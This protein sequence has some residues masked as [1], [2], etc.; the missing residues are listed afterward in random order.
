M[1]GIQDLREQA[2]QQNSLNFWSGLFAVA[3][4]APDNGKQV[5][6]RL[7][8]QQLTSVLCSA[9]ASGDGGE[10]ASSGASSNQ[11]FSGGPGPGLKGITLPLHTRAKIWGEN[12]LQTI[13]QQKWNVA[14]VEQI[15]L[16]IMRSSGLTEVFAALLKRLEATAVCGD[17]VE[18]AAVLPG[19]RH[20]QECQNN[21][22]KCREMLFIAKWLTATSNTKYDA[23]KL[24]DTFNIRRQRIN[25][26][27]FEED[28]D[29]DTGARLAIDCLVGQ[30]NINI[31]PTAHAQAT[32]NA[33]ANA[34]D[35]DPNRA[36]GSFP[37]W[38]PPINPCRELTGT[39]ARLCVALYLCLE[40]NAPSTAVQAQAQAT[41][42]SSS[43]VNVNGTN[44]NAM[45]AGQQFAASVQ[46]PKQISNVVCAL[47]TLDR[48]NDDDV[49]NSDAEMRAIRTF[50][51]C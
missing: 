44:E 3:T 48:L 39:R 7:L 31:R 51:S 50:Y 10:R 36:G 34:T 8:D 46:L 47:W 16:A 27:W 22:T 25:S 26:V 38:F 29:T 18:A 43:N 4:N 17:D 37:A 20:L 13:L 12:L 35:G 6:D 40:L 32:S 41:S 28:T 9:I 11:S 21:L 15:N 5:M 2:A 30:C 1:A 19:I 33:N 42:T 14:T 45:Y 23:A 49:G 24:R